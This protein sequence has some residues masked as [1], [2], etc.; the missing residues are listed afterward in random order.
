MLDPEARPPIDILCQLLADLLDLLGSG[1][2]MQI[3]KDPTALIQYENLIGTDVYMRPGL[4]RWEDVLAPG[5]FEQHKRSIQRYKDLISVRRKVFGR[6]HP[7]TLWSMSCFAHAH[8]FLRNDKYMED[9]GRED[10]AALNEVWEINKSRNGDEHPDTISAQV[11]LV[12]TYSDARKRSSEFM[13]LLGVQERI[14]GNEHP[15]TLKT[16]RLL[17]IALQ[18]CGERNSGAVIIK[19]AL[20]TQKRVMGPKHVETLLTKMEFAYGER[21]QGRPMHALLL[22]RDLMMEFEEIFGHDHVDTLWCLYGQARAH[23]DQ[24]EYRAAIR[25]FKQVLSPTMRVFGCDHWIVKVFKLR[26]AIAYR[27]MKYGR[28]RV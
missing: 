11:A 21:H 15:E 5:N 28:D 9:T 14:L 26:L 3:L 20:M 25:L 27:E 17:G 4:L 1:D 23:L 10:W 13:K 16:M 24:C 8:Q 7:N 12:A 19:D 18:S 22:Y 6:A 2:S